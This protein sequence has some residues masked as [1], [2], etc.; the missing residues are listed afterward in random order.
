[1][2]AD[3]YLRRFPQDEGGG[4]AGVKALLLAKAGRNDEAEAMIRRAN[5]IGRGYGH[6]HH[7]AYN[8]ASAYAAMNRPDEAVQWLEK[9]ADNGFPNYPYFELDPNL[10]SLKEH[11]GFVRLMVKLKRQWEQFKAEA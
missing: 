11:Q 7:T 2:I 3:D 9:A 8:I 1:V 5:E 6:F 4:F 10:Q